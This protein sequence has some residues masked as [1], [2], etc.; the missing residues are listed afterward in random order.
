MLAMLAIVA[1][2]LF[3]LAIAYLARRIG[4]TTGKQRV[5]V[6]YAG[7]EVKAKAEARADGH[8]RG[9]KVGRDQAQAE[10]NGVIDGLRSRL[11]A[12]DLMVKSLA[13]CWATT[14]DAL[15]HY[16]SL[17]GD[18][19][20]PD[21]IATSSRRGDPARAVGLIRNRITFLRATARN[22]GWRQGRG[23]LQPIVDDQAE[24]L[25]RLR[26]G[27]EHFRRLAKAHGIDGED[28]P[29]GIARKLSERVGKARDEGRAYGKAQGKYDAMIELRDAMA[30]PL[31][32]ARQAVGKIPWESRY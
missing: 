3:V 9:W 29:A 7:R 30:A 27:L 24:Q 12:G 5:E 32:Q 21:E 18:L 15:D 23:E 6:D 8:L 2:L 16:R 10:L 17:A 26:D 28:E 1:H 19:D 4:I 11:K 14:Y 13:A 31:G 25:A 20:V 22:E